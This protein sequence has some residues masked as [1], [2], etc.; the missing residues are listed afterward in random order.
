MGHYRRQVPH[1]AAGSS[2]GFTH[3]PRFLADTGCGSGLP[4]DAPVKSK[5]GRSQKRPKPGVDILVRYER[6]SCALDPVEHHVVGGVLS[7]RRPVGPGES[8]E[9]SGR[10][11]RIH[12]EARS[13]REMG[14]RIEKLAEALS[15]VP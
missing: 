9:F 7:G 5:D 14:V 2:G 3:Q 12:R 15:D 6:R 4:V 10:S 1:R 11:H 8:E 13:G